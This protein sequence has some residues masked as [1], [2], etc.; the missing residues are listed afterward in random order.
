M[1]KIAAFLLL[2]I[3]ATANVLAQSKKQALD[4][5]FTALHDNQRFNGN[6]LVADN[7]KIVYE[8][9][10]GYADF[11]NK[12]LNTNNTQFCIASITKT[13]TATGIFQLYEKGKLNIDDPV[14][15]YLPA[16]PYPEIRIRHLLSH[17]SGLP[18]YD[19]FFDSL[20]LAHPDTVFTNKDIVAR[21]AALKLPL[22]YQPGDN[23][24]YENVNYIFLSLIIES[25]TGIPYAEYIKKNVFEPAG[26]TKTFFPKATFYHYLPEEKTNLAE[27]Y[28]YPFVY[29]TAMQKTDTIKFIA[30]YWQ[31]YQFKGFG[32]I[33]TTTEDLLK[34]DQALYNGKLLSDATLA[35]A[36]T[37]TKLNNG[38]DSPV[39]IGLGWKVYNDNPFGQVVGHTG[40]LIG[41]S[42]VFLRNITRHQTVIV[43]DNTQNRT[44][45]VGGDALKILNGGKAVPLAKSAA[46]EYGRTL[47]SKGIEDANTDL[48]AMK[49]DSAHYSL[50]ET[51]FN[52][53]GYDL[54]A[55]NKLNLALEVFK[56]NMQLFPQSWNVYDSYGEA[57]L[58]NGQKDEAI[59]MYKK[60]VEL[61]PENENGVKILKDLSR[62]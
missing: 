11:A 54:M 13:F 53:L 29:S 21:Y 30:D 12:K 62:E 18:P 46:R 43:I 49:K 52:I 50:V 15:K 32:E 44:E 6:V 8:K 55:N 10:F 31:N 5:Y 33:I 34:Y 28:N 14:N 37:L 17:T 35:K 60:S 51:E 27:T 47:V 26:M 45:D 23:A 20:R 56:T 59:K 22:K 36:Y 61:N 19:K 57:L 4:K 1:K 40:G 3:I 9:S 41:L 25:I 2:L 7:G 16:F 39:E 58:Q 38:K 48:V 42:A 24:T